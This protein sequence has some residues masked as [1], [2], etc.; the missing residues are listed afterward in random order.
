MKPI[1]R[2]LLAWYDRRRRDLPWRREA[3]PYRTLVSEFMLQQT[4]VA[5]AIP[6][7]ERFV[8]RLPDVRALAAASEDD[9][10]ALWSGLGYYTR[11]RNLH[12]AACTVVERHGGRLP[13]DEEALRALPGVGPYTAAAVAAIAFGRR[14]FALDG[15]AARVVARLA[16]IDEP[17][18]KPATRD[19]LR[20]IGRAWVPAARAGD[21]AQ[22]VMELGATVCGPRAPACAV[23]PLAAACAA[24]QRGHTARIPRKSPPR[25]KLLV[26]LAAIRVRRA[27]RV[28]L[29][30]RPTGLLAKTWMLPGHAVVAGAAGGAAAADAARAAAAALGIAVG[31]IAR[32]GA[33]RHVFT[34]RDVTVDV[35]DVT[36]AAGGVRGEVTITDQGA[37]D[38][39]WADERRLGD[40]AVSSFLRKQLDLKGD[41]PGEQP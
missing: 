37:G 35:F 22:A 33:I 18:D 1:A 4:V 13:D 15:N 41:K 19:R 28:L 16:G 27:G 5:T 34:H 39:L 36:P 32:A 31:R 38:Q 26:R 30:R 14:T 17:I 6:Y 2:P 7:F 25:P 20:A 21:F 23:C 12:R 11:A 8:A 40:L 3:S 9:V 10:L 29:I 24:H